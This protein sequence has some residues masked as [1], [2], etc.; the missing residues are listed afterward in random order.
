MNDFA[1]ID[2]HNT[3]TLVRDLPGPVERVWDFLT[4]PKLLSRWFSEGVVADHVGGEVR[5]EMGADGRVTAFDPPHVLEYTWN[6][7]DHSRG[8][9]L[10]TIV[11]WELANVDSRVRLTLTHKRLSKLEA[12][13]HSAGWHT[14]VDR[15]SECVDGG[16]PPDIMERFA[17]LQS[18]YGK[19]F[20]VNLTQN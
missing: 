7:R 20:N 18:A 4:D 10:D 19:H 1:M 16:E 2:D 11:R 14:F 5:F 9:I 15:L 12:I 8:P 17:H 6:E 13:Q 3:V